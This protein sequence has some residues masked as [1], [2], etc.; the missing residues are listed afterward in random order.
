MN[1]R[2]LLASFFILPMYM[3]ASI[4]GTYEANGVDN[5]GY[6]YTAIVEITESN[7]IFSILW[8]YPDLS[9]DTGTGVRKDDS[10]AVV[11]DS[12]G[13]FGV[14]LYEIRHS[15]S[16]AL[17]GPWVYYDNSLKGCETLS[18]LCR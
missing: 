12:V 9:T 8:T 10:L 6:R 5:T 16:R 17:S 3:F 18:K 2:Y 1:F 11:F 4:V 14:Q 15:R 7:G 13:S